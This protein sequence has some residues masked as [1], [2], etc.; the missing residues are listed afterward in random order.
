LKITQ[1]SQ[2]KNKI[3]QFFK[4]QRRD[5]NISKGKELVEKEIQSFHIEPREVLTPENLKNVLER[6]NFMSEDDM[7]AAVGYQG[8]TAASIATRLTE[9]VRRTQ[10]QQQELSKTLEDLAA[11]SKDKTRKLPKTDSGVRVQGIDNLL[12]RL[13]KCCNPVP[14]DDIVGYI[15]K[16]RGVSVHRADCPNVQT[17]VTSQRLL[18]VDWLDNQSDAK[19]YHL[20][21]EISGYDRRGFLNDI[22]QAV[23]EMKTNITQVNG[24]SDRNKIAIINITILIHDI[25]HLRKIIKRIK[26]IKDVYTVTRTL[27]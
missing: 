2:A 17:E 16:G 11:D 15:T 5:E 3:R 27:H 18:Q 10:M 20:D 24:R 21:L 1:T 26:Q 22:L 19:Q 8:I 13:S 12:V 7:Y 23:N 14:G 6:F 9:D 4:K 25:D